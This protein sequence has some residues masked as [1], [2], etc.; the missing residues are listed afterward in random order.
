MT[1]S[2]EQVAANALKVTSYAQGMCARF[3]RSCAG[4]GALGDFDNDG[5]ADAV[6]MWKASKHRHEGDRNPPLGVFAF[7][8][9]GSSG[10]GHVAPTVTDTG[11][12]RSTDWPRAGQVNNVQLSTIERAWPGLTYLGWTDEPY[13][14]PIRS[15]ADERLGS[16]I[17]K[18]RAKR[19][20]LKLRLARARARRKALKVH[21]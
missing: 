12:V 16:K 14:N 9:G 3:S 21:D 13:G 8:S 1:I 15:E 5:D 11:V 18:W 17:D 2:R 4:F 10:H 19:A 20:L 7:W 6:D